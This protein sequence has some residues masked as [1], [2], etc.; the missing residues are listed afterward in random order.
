MS[1]SLST[2]GHKRSLPSFIRLVT[3]GCDHCHGYSAALVTIYAGVTRLATIH[4][5]FTGL[6]AGHFAGSFA[7]HSD[8]AL[9]VQLVNQPINEMVTLMVAF[10]LRDYTHLGK[11]IIGLIVITKKQKQQ[12]SG[13]PTLPCY[14][15]CLLD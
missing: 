8:I 14:S 15:F 2:M 9:V 7:G 10:F 6:S 11:K 3:I 13:L 4:T 5:I 12:H 1:A